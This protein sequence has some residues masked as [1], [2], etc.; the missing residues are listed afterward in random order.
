[1]GPEAIALVG[2]QQ[3]ANYLNA[4]H[5]EKKH[6]YLLHGPEQAAC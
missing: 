2:T 5:K 1:M 3:Y 6:G 4:S